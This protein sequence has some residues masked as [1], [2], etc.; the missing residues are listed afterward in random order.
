MTVIHSWFS[1]FKRFEPE[2]GMR[3]NNHCYIRAT[4]P[5]L[6]S[7]KKEQNNA[8]RRT[9]PKICIVTPTM[10][11]MVPWYPL[12]SSSTRVHHV[13]GQDAHLKAEL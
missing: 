8:S 7:L 2:L 13:Q 3:E 11:Y 9:F 5:K 4:F 12:Q 6:F 1:S 10:Q